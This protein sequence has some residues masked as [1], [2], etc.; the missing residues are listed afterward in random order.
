MSGTTRWSSKRA[1]VF[2]T[3][4]AAI[5]LG[6]V[7]RFPYLVGE[8]GGGAFVL[9]YLLCVLI[10]ALPLLVVEMVLGRVGRGNPIEVM[11]ALS[12]RSK[13]PKIWMLVGALTVLTSYLIST[14]YV[15]I[16]GW[17]A[18]YFIQAVRGMLSFQSAVIAKSH[19]QI[20]QTHHWRVIAYTGTVIILAMSILAL[21]V[22]KGLERAVVTIFPLLFLLMLCLL[23]FSIHTGYFGH[24]LKY[25]F[26][27]DFTKITHKT[28]V[29][30]MGQAF[31]SVGIGMGIVVMM[32]AYLP[33]NVS[34]MECAFWV[35][36][37]DTGFAL[38]SGLM[39]FPIVFAYQLSPEAGPSLIFQTLPIAFSHMSFS[40]LIG[41][42]F[43]LMLFFAAFSSVIALVEP[44]VCAVTES[45]NWS[46][47]KTVV[48]IGLVCFGFSLGT[49]GSFSW[50]GVFTWHGI[51]FF[52][53]LDFITAAIMLPVGGIFLA[54]F[55]GWCLD[56]TLISDELGW[57]SGR[58]WFRFWL[59]M[60]RWLAPL[61]IFVILLSAV[62]LF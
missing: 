61:I 34:L 62:G 38:L 4:A 54:L 5:G 18:D 41:S 20:M 1:F 51:S 35:I 28:V 40:I 22:K 32:S 11:R 2:A 9:T 29:L 8:N 24:A 55:T 50:P 26:T 6:N 7:W 15:V 25:M 60:C 17:V 43:F 52:S 56:K 48:V 37:A 31:F 39:I 21:G 23:V 57:S 3:A 19:F 14:Y 45:L 33:E 59:F 47:M 36:L 46:R 16:T 44:V 10:L 53:G 42:L 27:P 30:A 12:S 58:V 49:V 13:A